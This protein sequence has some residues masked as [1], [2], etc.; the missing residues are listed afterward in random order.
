MSNSATF[1]V[2]R[3]RADEWRWRLVARNGRI[4]ADS[5]EG[6]TSKQ[7]AERGIESV[8]RSAADATVEYLPED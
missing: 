6:Y 1:E 8:K 2:F 7:G 3:D 5:G 4:I